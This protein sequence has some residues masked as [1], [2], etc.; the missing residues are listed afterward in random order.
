[1]TRPFWVAL[2][3]T[4][5]SFIELCKPLQYDKA[6]IREGGAWLEGSFIRHHL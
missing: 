6:V 5:H 2:P 1:M 4:V 3:G